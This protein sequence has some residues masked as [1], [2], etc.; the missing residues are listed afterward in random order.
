MKTSY[1]LKIE[2]P[3]TEHWGTMSK[4]DFGRHCKS[5]SK[6]VVDFS[7]LSD[8]EI[9][10]YLSQNNSD[11]TCGRL[12]S[13]Q[14]NRII[15]AETEKRLK[16]N[17]IVAALLLIGTTKVSVA[18]D[19]NKVQKQQ[20]AISENKSVSSKSI[21]QQNLQDSLRKV[22]EGVVIAEEDKLTIPGVH[23]KINGSNLGA[24]TDAQGKF[25]LPI[26]DDLYGKK[27]ELQLNSL[28]F[29]TL[30]IQINPTDLE[31]PKEFKMCTEAGLMGEVVIVSVKKKWWKFWKRN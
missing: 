9:I 6:D 1:I 16:Y 25:K 24:I 12:E 13:H 5:C 7:H 14:L 28:G 30:V 17:R 23:I 15:K 19:K 21:Q 27:L 29:K 22:I 3:C 8:G 4:N 2:N 18:Q 26:P 11:K 31:H 10:K 20:T